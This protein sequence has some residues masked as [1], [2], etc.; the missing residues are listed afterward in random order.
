MEWLAQ[1]RGQLIGL[2]TAPLIYFVE[3]NPIYIALVDALFEA[4]DRSE[5]RVITSTVTLAV[6]L[7][8]E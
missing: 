8:R 1:L 7:N 2:D 6:V 4:L 3:E 5:F